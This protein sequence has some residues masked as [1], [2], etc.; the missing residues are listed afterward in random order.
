MNIMN[1]YYLLIIFKYNYCQQALSLKTKNN[2]FLHKNS[3]PL[4]FYA[5][6]LI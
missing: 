2:T 5:F 1:F 4:L 3:S 6:L